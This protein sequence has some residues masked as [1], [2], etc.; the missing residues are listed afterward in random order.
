MT[1]EAAERCRS[2]ENMLVCCELI[3]AARYHG[4]TTYQAIAQ[5]LG[6]PL[7]G[8]Y[9]GSKISRILEEISRSEHSQGRPLLSALAVGVSGWPGAGFYQLARDL[10][11]LEED[12]PDVERRFWQ[13]ECKAVYAEWGRVFKS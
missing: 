1:T 9:M 7:S 11:R 6:L 12:D 13:E 8:N 10:G 2:K 4:I 3:A 5:V